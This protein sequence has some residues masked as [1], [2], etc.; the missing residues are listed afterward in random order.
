MRNTFLAATVVG[1]SSLTL[2]QP[3][4]A[5]SEILKIGVLTDMSGQFAD[6]AGSGTVFSVERADSDGGTNIDGKPIQVIVADHQNKAD[7]ASALAR[8]WFSEDGVDVIVNAAG[9]AVALAVVEMAKTYNKT[10]LITGA[11]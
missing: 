5:N 9:S 6:M 10:A 2:M 1:F 8:K 3:I 4:W 11:L 7:V